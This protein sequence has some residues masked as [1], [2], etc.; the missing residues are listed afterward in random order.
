MRAWGGIL[1]RF[2]D[3]AELLTVGEIFFCWA[4]F[5]FESY[6][7]GTDAVALFD[8]YECGRNQIHIRPVW[9]FNI[10][11]PIGCKG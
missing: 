8:V 9:A 10:E 6:T 2:P 3:V 11:M 7:I 1:S 5:G 4:G